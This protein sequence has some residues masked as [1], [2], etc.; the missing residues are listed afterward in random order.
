MLS[1]SCALLF[2]GILT[3]TIGKVLDNVAVII[4]CHFSFVLTDDGTS[5]GELT[6]N[7]GCDGFEPHVSVQ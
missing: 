3:A 7:V 5:L 1:C 2:R 6:S 4:G